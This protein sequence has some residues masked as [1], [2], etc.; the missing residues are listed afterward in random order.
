VKE[1]FFVRPARVSSA[2]WDLEI[3][4]IEKRELGGF[5]VYIQ[6]GNRSAGASKSF[7]I[8]Q[9]YFK[10]PW[11]EFLDK[12]L[13]LASPSSFYVNKTDLENAPGLKE[14]LGF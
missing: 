6:A 10:L 5:S 7:Y 1:S 12:Y 9:D 11:E 4:K 2:G 14:F 8:P 3:Y 13:Q